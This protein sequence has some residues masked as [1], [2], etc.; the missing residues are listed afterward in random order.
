MPGQLFQIAGA[1]AEQIVKHVTSCYQM[2]DAI[3]EI[4]KWQTVGWHCEIL[5]H[6][7]KVADGSVEWIHYITKTVIVTVFES[8]SCKL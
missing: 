8:E 2:A 5:D 3:V 4:V 6:Y 7:T 1:I